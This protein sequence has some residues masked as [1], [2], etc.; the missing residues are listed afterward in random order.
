[1]LS[2]VNFSVSNRSR[3]IPLQ[4]ERKNPSKQSQWDVCQLEIE[5]KIP[6]N[7]CECQALN[8]PNQRFCC[9]YTAEDPS[10]KREE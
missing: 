1:M 10:Q 3:T 9:D 5:E 6:T 8:S 2:N 4:N 7:A